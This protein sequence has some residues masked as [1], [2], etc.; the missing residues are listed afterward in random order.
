MICIR[1]FGCQQPGARDYALHLGI[2]LQLTNILRDV[3]SDLERGRI[4]IPLEDLAACGCSV[5]DLVAG[6]MSE[7]V[8]RVIEF[9]CHRARE[10]YRR[11]AEVRPPDDRRRL[12][13]AEIM[14]AVY[15]ETL[16]RI[17]RNGYDVFRTRARVPRPQQALIAV[18]QWLWQT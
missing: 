5:E 9:E 6:R 10:L 1:I 12:L 17:E 4:Y 13:A 11:A 7:P 16:R 2:A 18:R 15:L 14:R 3:K 8:R